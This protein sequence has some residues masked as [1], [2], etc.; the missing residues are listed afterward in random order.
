LVRLKYRKGAVM[1]GGK[2]FGLSP[3]TFCAATKRHKRAKKQQNLFEL[4]V[5]FCGKKI[6]VTSGFYTAA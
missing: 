4:F 1:E 5:P 3:D 6:S 2:R